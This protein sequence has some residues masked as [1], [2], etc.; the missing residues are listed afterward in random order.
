V[1]GRIGNDEG[2]LVGGEIAIGDVDGDALFAF[3][4]QA[5]EQQREV[6]KAEIVLLAG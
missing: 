4:L 3:R 6:G 5:V 2:T 1:A